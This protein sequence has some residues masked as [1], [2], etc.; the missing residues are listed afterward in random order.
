MTKL[1]L[2]ILG[3]IVAPTLALANCPSGHQT[4][5]SACATGQVFDPV[6]KACVTSSS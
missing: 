1:T 5:A 3:L 6:L 4:S 2:A